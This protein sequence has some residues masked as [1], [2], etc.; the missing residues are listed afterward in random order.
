MRP[1]AQASLT[2]LPPLL[3]LPKPPLSPFLVLSLLLAPVRGVLIRL[4]PQNTYPLFASGGGH[5]L[6]HYRSRGLSAC[7]HGR[8]GSWLRPSVG[9]YYMA[10][11]T[12]CYMDTG[13]PVPRLFP[14]SP[15]STPSI[16]VVLQHQQ[17]PREGVV[18]GPT[19][20]FCWLS[21]YLPYA[22]MQCT[23]ITDTKPHLA[24][25]TLPLH[26]ST[27]PSLS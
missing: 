25:A 23:P 8:D 1:K 10:S 27:F 20:L 13:T 26:Q 9:G 7:L 24:T 22:L 6:T 11:A 18:T 19:V 12:C 15:L 21:V 5:S 2:A 14:A 16:M 4:L 17:V 3:P